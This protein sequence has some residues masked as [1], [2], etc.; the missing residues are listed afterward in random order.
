[1]LN[2]VLIFQ[3]VLRNLIL[4][5]WHRD[6]CS[7]TGSQWSILSDSGLFFC[8][9]W[10]DGVAV[11][12]QQ[13]GQTTHCF[14][15]FKIH[16]GHLCG[17][18]H[19]DVVWVF[20]DLHMTKCFYRITILYFVMTLYYSCERDIELADPINSAYG[21]FLSCVSFFHALF[22][23]CIKKTKLVLILKYGATCLAIF[24]YILPQAFYCLFV[25]W[26]NWFWK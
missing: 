17:I 14:P 19:Q 20:L 3:V 13:P 2:M 9:L 6:I 21:I 26:L 15:D 10:F 25:K 12:V 23:N 8:C 11:A 1:M 4:K 18:S 16:F 7:Q 5:L 24:D 22:L